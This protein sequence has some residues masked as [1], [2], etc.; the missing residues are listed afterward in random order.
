MIKLL[1]ILLITEVLF[2]PHPGGADYVELY[3]DSQDAVLLSDYYLAKVTDG[4]ITK[5]YQISDSRTVAPHE[6]VVVTT[7][8]AYVAD[9]FSVRFPGKIVEM[10]T[11]P[12]YPD[13]AGTVMVTDKDSV[14]VDQLDYSESMHSRLLRDKEGVS[15]ERRSLSAATNEPTNWY[16]AASTTATEGRMGMGTPT[17]QNS[18]SKELLF[19]EG[20]FAVE[21]RIFSPDG[22]GYND[23]VDMTYD[24]SEEDLSADIRVFDSKGRLVRH[25]L[26][27][28]LLGQHG[29]VS[30]DGLDDDGRRCHQGIYTILI[31]AINLSGTKQITKKSVT[32]VIR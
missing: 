22:D 32:L 1:S 31:E 27:G 25:L 4:K 5:L 24:L 6:Y 12:S 17:A 26:R 8:S 11:M 13:A 23:L 29:V 2:N 21:P 7:D 3:N 19:V 20:D 9:N 18:Q 30:W 14:V 28:G 10:K 16:S 15:L